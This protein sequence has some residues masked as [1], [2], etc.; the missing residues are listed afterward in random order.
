[1]ERLRDPASRGRVACESCS[2]SRSPTVYLSML[3]SVYLSQARRESQEQ[4]FA[5]HKAWCT[6]GKGKDDA[7]SPAC[8]RW[9]EWLG[10]TE[11]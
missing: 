2:D 1:M 7:G 9:R 5:M 3:P 11:L 10:K 6:E 4:F 8:R